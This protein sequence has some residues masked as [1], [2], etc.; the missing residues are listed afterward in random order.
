[1]GSLSQSFIINLAITTSHSRI[2]SGSHSQSFNHG[3]KN[4]WGQLVA[5][6]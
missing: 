6:G 4:R 3:V 2:Q 1:M 5:A